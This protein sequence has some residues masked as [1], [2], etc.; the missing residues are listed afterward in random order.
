VTYWLRRCSRGES[1]IDEPAQPADEPPRDRPLLAVTVVH[2]HRHPP[3]EHQPGQERHTLG[4]DDYVGADAAQWTQS[5]P[6]ATMA[7]PAKM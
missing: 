4:V 6:A 1:R 7:R 2:Q 5:E 3:A